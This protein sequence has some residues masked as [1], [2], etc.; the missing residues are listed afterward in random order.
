MSLW[1]G[2]KE[3]AIEGCEMKAAVSKI[4]RGR[5]IN[6]PYKKGEL[7]PGCLAGKLLNKYRME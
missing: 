4:S 2:R 7:D 6:Q 1:C 3:V 5:K